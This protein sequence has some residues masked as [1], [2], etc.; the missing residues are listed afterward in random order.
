MM[1][2]SNGLKAC[3]NAVLAIRKLCELYGCS[4]DEARC[5]V[6][7]KRRVVYVL[8]AGRISS[9]ECFEADFLFSD[10]K[11]K[12]IPNKNNASSTSSQTHSVVQTTSDEQTPVHSPKIKRLILTLVPDGY[13]VAFCA[14]QHAWLGVVEYGP[15]KEN[16]SHDGPLR[17]MSPLYK[18]TYVDPF[19]FVDSKFSSEFSD[20]P[21]SAFREAYAK[22]FGA[23]AHKRRPNGRLFFGFHYINMQ[24]KLLRNFE[25]MYLGILTDAEEMLRP[26]DGVGERVLFDRWCAELAIRSGK[27]PW[28]I[29]DALVANAQSNS[30]ASLAEFL[31][32]QTGL[33]HSANATRNPHLEHDVWDTSNSILSV[34]SCSCCGAPGNGAEEL[35]LQRE[36][37]RKKTVE[38]PIRKRKV[39]AKASTAATGEGSEG[40][41]NN[42]NHINNN[43]NNN[44]VMNG[45]LPAVGVSLL[46]R[47]KKKAKRDIVAS[48]WSQLPEANI[49]EVLLQWT[50]DCLA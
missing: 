38:K 31:R 26:R 34:S 11:P 15:T 46:R 17:V 3:K 7:S 6:N 43:N 35:T 16:V 14:F 23:P 50:R 8:S 12:R 22:K 48:Q 47:K 39:V 41:S 37:K 44:S 45:P 27:L 13:T 40:S 9:P 10:D 25:H 19:G 42:N 20:T 49:P 2:S 32:S 21:T 5:E 24:L 28:A 30:P 18:V 33:I 29:H 36:N 4:Q 1:S